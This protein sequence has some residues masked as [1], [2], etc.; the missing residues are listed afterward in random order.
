MWTCGPSSAGPGPEA[1]RQQRT[2]LLLRA[3]HH[4]PR[5]LSGY[6]TAAESIDFRV[7]SDGRRQ[8]LG[9][10]R[11]PLFPPEM[12]GCRH[13]QLYH[14]TPGVPSL[15]TPTEWTDMVPGAPPRQYR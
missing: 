9:R 2:L 14:T 1:E 10:P 12:L 5:G 13:T 4:P 6:E 3:S 7:L 8:G 15:Q 11:R